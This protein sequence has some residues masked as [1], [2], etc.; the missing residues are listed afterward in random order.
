MTFVGTEPFQSEDRPDD[1]DDRIERADL[2]QVDA[3]DRHVVHGGFGFGESSKELDRAVLPVTRER[4]PLDRRRDL[5][6]AVVVVVTRGSGLGRLGS[7]AALSTPWSW[8]P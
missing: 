4:R 7:R 6:Q 1:V 3:L 2:V 8:W 5:A